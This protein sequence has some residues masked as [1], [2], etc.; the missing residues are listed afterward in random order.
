MHIRYKPSFL[1]DFKK[2]PREVR[3]EAH[4]KI[5]VFADNPKDAVLKTH[6]LKGK[7]KNFSSFSVTYA[8]RIVFAYEEKDIV[9]FMA[10]GTH[11]VYK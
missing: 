4:I 5:A 10:I 6:K 9:V 1:R 3:E 7:L 11:D 2:L 8:H